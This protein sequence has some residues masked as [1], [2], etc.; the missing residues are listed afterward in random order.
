MPHPLDTE[1]TLHASLPA[2]HSNPLGNA[3]GGFSMRSQRRTDT[4]T[5][6]PYRYADPC[7]HAHASE[8]QPTMIICACRQ[9]TTLCTKITSCQL[10]KIT[11]QAKINSWPEDD[12]GFSPNPPACMINKGESIPLPW[13]QDFLA[14]NLDVASIHKPSEDHLA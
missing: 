8:E 14:S 9:R 1:T 5:G 2:E 6:M 11:E 4:R 10:H 3:L 12:H 13:D 7:R